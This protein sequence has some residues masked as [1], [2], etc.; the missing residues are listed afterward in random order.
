[1]RAAVWLLA[2]VGLWSAHAAEE[3]IVLENGGSRLEI[4]PDAGGRVVSFRHDDSPNF[5]EANEAVLAGDEPLPEAEFDAKYVPLDGHIVWIAPQSAWWQR[6]R[7]KPYR[8]DWPP[9]PWWEYG[10]FKVV[11]RTASAVTLDGPFSPLASLRMR[12]SFA[13]AADGSVTMDYTI[14]NPTD[15]E[16]AGA[17]WSNTRVVP[18]AAVIVDFRGEADAEVVFQPGRKGRTPVPLEYE[19]I[20]NYVVPRHLA[21]RAAGKEFNGKL[22]VTA[23][24]RRIAAFLDGWVFVKEADRV[25]PAG[26]TAPGQRFIEVFANG[27]PGEAGY[28]E[29]E[30]QGPYGVIAPG[31]ARHFRERWRLVPDG[32]AAGDGERGEWLDS[33]RE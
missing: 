15:A 31:E 25:T 10:R 1:M 20:R 29:L 12:K 26:E 8:V 2:V 27:R 18:E 11:E 24:G 7:D 33:L 4:V 23:E 17:I 6:N 30:F 16:V 32:G 3:R 21:M 14:T 13:V 22:A 5:I 19:V 9:D 28:L